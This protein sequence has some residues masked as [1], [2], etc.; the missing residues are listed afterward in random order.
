MNKKIIFSISVLNEEKR[1]ISVVESIKNYASD[2]VLLDAG[3]G[4]D[5]IINAR[6][7]FNNIRV[8]KVGS[9]MFDVV[10][11][12]NA[13]KDSFER[14]ISDEWIFPMNASEEISPELGN[15]LI[16]L[17]N[18]KAHVCGITFY[19]QS[20]TFG[21]RTHHRKLFYL[22]NALRGKVQVR[23]FKYRCWDILKSRI[24]HEFSLLPK[25]RRNMLWLNPFFSN[26][27]LRHNRDGCM[28]D[29]ELK[30]I[31]YSDE[32]ALQL[33][34]EGFRGGFFAFCVIVLPSLIY[35]P[36]HFFFSKKAG[37]VG[38][39]HIFY[40]FQVWSKLAELDF[41]R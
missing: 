15:C 26:K 40:K 21:V 13:L 23:L 37:I 9:D 34:A 3:C 35:F 29:F 24:H 1:I 25:Y 38:V 17:I 11:R 22:Y 10:G 28:R 27:I 2:I 19:R 33:Y 7:V 14:D 16:D 20:F 6:K 12:I 36:F 8:V 32:E 4:D 5:T 41:D 31:K 30:H 18:N 39:Y